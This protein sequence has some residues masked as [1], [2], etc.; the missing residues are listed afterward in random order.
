MEN[1][2]VVYRIIDPMLIKTVSYEA[3]LAIDNVPHQ[4]LL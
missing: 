1:Q 4:L 3:Q 2:F